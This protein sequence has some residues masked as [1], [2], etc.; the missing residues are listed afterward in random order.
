MAYNITFSP[1]AWADYLFWQTE[2]KKTLKRINKLLRELQR[3]G[4]VQGIGK[5]ELLRYGRGMSKRI[6][7]K[8]RLI[9][10]L[11]GESLVILSCRGHYE[12]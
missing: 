7:D 4:A 10:T 3:D 5:A 8:N 9:Y 6:D 2:D 12:N 1:D 11:E